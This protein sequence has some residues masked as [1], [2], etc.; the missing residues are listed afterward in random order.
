M[1]S[2]RILWIVNNSYTWWPWNSQ[3]GQWFC[4]LFIIDVSS[5][6]DTLPLKF[7]KFDSDTVRRAET[8]RQKVITNWTTKFRFFRLW[9]LIYSVHTRWCLSTARHFSCISKLVRKRV[10]EYIL[11][12]VTTLSVSILAI[13]LAVTVNSTVGLM[14]PV[15]IFGAN[16][17][18]SMVKV[19]G[20]SVWVSVGCSISVPVSTSAPEIPSSS[21]Q[22]APRRL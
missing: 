5:I 3:V 12:N 18:K 17:E 13:F 20:I 10:S 2:L 9:R 1:Y 19:G 15:G 16:S 6:V 21:T 22:I 11:C 4:S 8:I 14:V 7:R